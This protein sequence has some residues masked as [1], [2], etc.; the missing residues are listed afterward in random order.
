MKKLASLAALALIGAL[1][2]ACATTPPPSPADAYFKNLRTLCGQTHEGRL[3]T[4]DPADADF[5]GKHL[6]LGP[7]DCATADVVRIPFAVGEDRSRTWVVTRLEGDRVRLKHDHRHTDGTEDALSQYGGDS[8][9]AGTATRQSFPVDAFTRELFIAQNIP[10]SLPN[11]WSVDI[12]PGKR[13]GYEL[14]RPGRLFQVEF[15]LAAA[16]D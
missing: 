16:S 2:S 13:F 14:K 3:A 6:V 5:A 4:N 1:A 10:R 15:D 9:D 8:I 7:V 11:V 12:E